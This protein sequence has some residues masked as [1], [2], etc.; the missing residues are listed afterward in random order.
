MSSNVQKMESTPL[1]LSPSL[2]SLPECHGATELE[3]SEWSVRADATLVV[4]K[5]CQGGR[6][7]HLKA[8]EVMP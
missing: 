5:N 4:G 3:A 6:E 8:Q 1:T 7:N 2:Y